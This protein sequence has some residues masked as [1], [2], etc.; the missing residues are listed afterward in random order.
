MIYSI[1]EYNK[2]SISVVIPVKNGGDQLSDCL[3]SITNQIGVYIKEIIVLDSNSSD[4]S[5][6]VALSF[7]AQ[8]ISIDSNAFNH[9]LSRNIGVNAASGDLVYFT[10]QDAYLSDFHMLEKVVFHFND[11]DVKAV[12]GIQGVP[13]RPRTNPAIWFKRMEKPILETMY[14]QDG[15]FSLFSKQ[16]RVKYNCWD[17]VNAMYRRVALLEIPFRETNYCEDKI[18]ADE[19]FHAG[20]K[21]LRD[22]SFLVY[23]Y[24]HMYFSYVI[25][26]KFIVD[27][28]YYKRFNIL[29]IFPNVITIFS[30]RVWILLR[31]EE[32]NFMIKF[33]WI[34][35]N[36]SS[37][38]AEFCITLIFKVL[39]L[40]SG[41][42]GL[43]LAYKIFC[44]NVPQGFKK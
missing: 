7:N 14:F 32:L 30:K 24:H 25:S 35:H 15:S 11:I 9:G 41:I 29:P 23:H 6:A 18:W 38:L 27:L 2:L 13:H 33:Y 20:W 37:L 3:R 22:P 40:V 19:A 28:F 39:H 1:K 4:N 31:T 36:F 21:L 44:P 34:F 17:N 26:Q 5:V 12:V 42:K 10:V 16:D 43:N 8:I